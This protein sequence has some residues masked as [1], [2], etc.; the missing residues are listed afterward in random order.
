MKQPFL[1]IIIPTYNSIN[2][3]Q[4][5]LDS[6]FV[7]T[8]LNFEIV[9]IDGCSSDGTLEIIQKNSA[10]QNSRIRWSSEKDKGIYD[11][12]NKGIKI[13]KGEWIYFLGSDD[14]L[15][16]KDVLLKINQKLLDDNTLDVMYGN[17]YSTRF[18]GIYDGKFT[19]DKIFK[20][21]IC[22]QAIIFNKRIFNIIGNFNLRYKVQSDWDHNLRWFLSNK[23]K[24]KY[25][26]I[27]VAEYKDGGFSS[28][29]EEYLFNY[30]KKWKFSLFSPKTLSNGKKYLIIKNIFIES[31]KIKDYSK[32]LIILYKT[33]SILLNIKTKNF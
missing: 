16:N 11:A 28:I 27:I 25:F 6:I 32:M 21:N 13:A 15:F 33:P 14:K 20:I 17:V 30:E 1:S 7:Q 9:I 31:F 29:N 3:L 5:C 24:K 22:H 26:D 23:I 4:N 2:V 19:N 12:M 8:F 18:A 10:S